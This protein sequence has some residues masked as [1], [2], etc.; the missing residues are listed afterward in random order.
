MKQL[1]V[2]AALL[3]APV[4]VLAGEATSRLHVTGL[5]CPS[6]SYIVA[7]ALK[8]VET[9]EIAEFVEGEAED[10]LYLLRYDDAVTDAEALIDAVT[11]VGYGATLAPDSGS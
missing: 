7:T 8:R 3:L 5:T 4:A 2:A 11:G 6:C 9:V 10:G 1:V